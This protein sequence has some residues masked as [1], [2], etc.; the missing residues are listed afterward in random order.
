[1]NKY[2]FI[3]TGAALFAALV[4]FLINTLSGSQCNICNIYINNVIADTVNLNEDGNYELL[5]ESGDC[6]ILYSIKNGKLDVTDA[7]CADKLCVHQPAISKENDSIV[8]LPN[9]VVFTVVSDKNGKKNVDERGYDG[10][11]N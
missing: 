10:F 11:T 4:W 2:D 9:K 3:L 1:M 6:I 7:E 5:S 8:C